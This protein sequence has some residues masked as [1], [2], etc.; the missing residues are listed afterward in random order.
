MDAFARYAL[1]A[2]VLASSL[3][4][5]A[6]CVVGFKYGLAP[7]AEDDPIELTHRRLFVTHFA[8]AFAVV[9][10]ALTAMLAGSVLML[11]RRSTSGVVG[12]RNEVQSVQ[13]RLDGVEAIVTQMTQTLERAIRRFDKH[14]PAELHR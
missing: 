9:A 6:V 14:D 3:G 2:C 4:G 1:F 11:D 7:P 13:R 8:H 10:F 5:I 12:Q